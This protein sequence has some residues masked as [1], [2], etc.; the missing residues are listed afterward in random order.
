MIEVIDISFKI[1]E[2]FP[3]TIV[4]TVV[5][6]MIKFLEFLH[7]MEYVDLCLLIPSTFHLSIMEFIIVIT[8]VEVGTVLKIPATLPLVILEFIIVVIKVFIMV[9]VDIGLKIPATLPL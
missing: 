3:P 7:V 1:P 4:I 8:M 9:D 6:L 2:N 5:F